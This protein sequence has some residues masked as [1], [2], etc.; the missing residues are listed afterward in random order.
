MAISRRDFLRLGGGAAGAGWASLRWPALLALGQA[1]CEA[2]DAGAAFANLD[3]PL[4]QD[5]AAIAAQIVP[6]DDTGPG[7]EEAG[8]IYFID[9]ALGSHMAGAR[10]LLAS[11]A[12]D[13]AVH[14]E[15]FARLPPD[16]QREL[17]RAHDDSPWFGA[18]R[19]LTVAGMFAMP[20]HGGNR[21]HAGWR[22]LGFDHRHHWAPPFGHYDVAEH[23]DG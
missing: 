3:A 22:L 1:A 13:L 17:L 14:G 18:M 8:V 7:A 23:D 10:A 6:A 9:Q 16:R 11:G 15:R 20:V 19:Y 5:L 12:D 21:E 2:R 4:A